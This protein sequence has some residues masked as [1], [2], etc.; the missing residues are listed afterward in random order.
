VQESGSKPVENV[1]MTTLAIAIKA[2][3]QPEHP[4]S[5][6]VLKLKYLCQLYEA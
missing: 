1:G 4:L 5:A 2:L 6:Q 3:W